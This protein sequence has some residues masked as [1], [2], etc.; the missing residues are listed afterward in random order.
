MSHTHS[1]T[2][3]STHAHART[4]Y[5]THTACDTCEEHAAYQHVTQSRVSEWVSERGHTYTHIMHIR[6]HIH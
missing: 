5:I 3:H 6:I 1:H 4:P 2:Q